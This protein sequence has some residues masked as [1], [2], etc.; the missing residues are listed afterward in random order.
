MLDFFYII[1]TCLLRGVWHSQE[2]PCKM[3][4]PNDLCICEIKWKVYFQ[5]FK[6]ILLEEKDSRVSCKPFFCFSWCLIGIPEA[7]DK[8]KHLTRTF[9]LLKSN[10]S[11]ILHACWLF[12]IHGSFTQV[13]LIVRSFAGI[14]SSLAINLCTR[15]LVITTALRK[16]LVNFVAIS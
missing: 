8:T 1:N 6:E 7:L 3:V 2:K 10:T 5:S 9:N 16:F 12:Q 13:R 14:V 4:I 11:I 15:S